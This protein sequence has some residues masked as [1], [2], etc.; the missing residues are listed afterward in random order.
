MTDLF[1]DLVLLQRMVASQSGAIKELRAQ[2]EAINQKLETKFGQIEIQAE[3]I[4]EL[5]AQI[6]IQAEPQ[7]GADQGSDSADQGDDSAVPGQVPGQ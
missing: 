1:H 7:R 5:T 2:I 6:E 3:H 4:K